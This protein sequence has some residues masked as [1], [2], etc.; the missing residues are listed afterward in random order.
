MYPTP[1]KHLV[2]AAVRS[3]AIVVFVRR[4]LPGWHGML[5]GYFEC[6]KL[7]ISWAWVS[8]A[9]IKTRKQKTGHSCL[10]G[11]LEGCAAGELPTLTP[12]SQF[13]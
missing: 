6:H 12:V 7:P 1:M 11:L 2:S 10:A 5:I 4:H 13:A 3:E 8:R 9:L